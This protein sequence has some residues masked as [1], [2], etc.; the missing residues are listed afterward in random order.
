MNWI[1]TNLNYSKFKLFLIF[2]ITYHSFEYIVNQFGIS[3]IEISILTRLIVAIPV[4]ILHELVH[5][6]AFCFFLRSV[7]NIR[8]GFMPKYFVFYCQADGEYS[9]QELITSTLAPFALLTVLFALVLFFLGLINPLIWLF[10]F[11]N[12][13]FSVL[14]LYNAFLI[15]KTYT[16]TNMFKLEGF[17][18]YYKEL[19]LD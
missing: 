14:D 8:F 16:T 10:V 15:S 18:L 13:I 4:I 6:V 3:F 7:R 2:L 5:G 11:Y 19:I 12:T 9:F 17:K 1:I